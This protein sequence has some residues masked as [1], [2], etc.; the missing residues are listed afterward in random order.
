MMTKLFS[1]VDEAMDAIPP[2]LYFD[3]GLDTPEG[4]QLVNQR[5]LSRKHIIA[6]AKASMERLGTYIDVL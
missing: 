6:G 2:N 3:Q 4:I 5:G 1:P